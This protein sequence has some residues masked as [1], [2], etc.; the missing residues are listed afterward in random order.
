MHERDT[1]QVKLSP[2]THVKVEAHGIREAVEF[3][4]EHPSVGI[5]LY[6]H[7]LKNVTEDGPVE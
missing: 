7:D 4:E 1:Y 6:E 2:Y 5:E 3:A